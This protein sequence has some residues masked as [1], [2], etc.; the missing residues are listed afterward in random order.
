[1]GDWR[2][3]LHAFSASVRNRDDWSASRSNRIT[4]G[5]KTGTIGLEAVW[6]PGPVWIVR[7]EKNL[8]LPE[9][10]L[11]FLGCPAPGSLYAVGLDVRVSPQCLFLD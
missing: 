1:M 4:P 7:T 10:E 11:L 2:L 3:E 8:P 9:I 5:K 6:V